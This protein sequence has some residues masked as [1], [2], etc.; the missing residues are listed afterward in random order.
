MTI[1]PQGVTSAE[2]LSNINILLLQHFWWQFWLSW[3][4]LPSKKRWD[5]ADDQRNL[6][7][8]S[9][10]I[11][12]G[13]TNIRS[14]HVSLCG[15]KICGTKQVSEPKISNLTQPVWY[16]TFDWRHTMLLHHK[17]IYIVIY[18]Y[19]HTHTSIASTIHLYDIYFCWMDWP[20]KNILCQI[21]RAEVF[22]A[23][24]HSKSLRPQ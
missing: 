13:E 24:S 1:H 10:V 2:I 19:I 22:M 3:P 7:L 11:F 17:E 15:L 23:W 12:W 20:G 9:T 6:C 4:H 16:I 8:F 21:L 5:S 14:S 18:T